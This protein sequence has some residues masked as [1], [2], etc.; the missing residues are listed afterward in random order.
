METPTGPTRNRS[1]AVVLSL[2]AT[3]LG[4][5]YCGRLGRGLVMFL[6]SLLFAPVIVVAA[7]MPPAT[8][9]LAGLILALLTVLGIHVFSVVDA[10]K[11]SRQ[12]CVLVQSNS[13]THPLV[14]PLY[15]L[16]GLTYQAG[17]LYFIRSNIFEAFVV[18]SASEVPTLLPGDRF[19]VNKTT[20]QRRPV[21]RGDVVVFRVPSEPC[22]KWVKRVIALPGDTV[23]VKDN[24]V[25]VN[26]NRLER[27]RL[28]L[29][30][31][32]FDATL[33]RGEV[34]QETNAG[35][36]YRI[37]LASESKPLPDYPKATVP[38]GCCFLLGDNRNNSR[39]SRMLGFVPLDNLLGDV[40]YRFLPIRNWS[41]FGAL[42]E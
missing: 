7:L 28:P 8:F 26:G 27:E 11:L 39:D 18:P 2:A 29:A 5:V 10:F 41:R 31:L 16:V 22:L 25:F 17:G 35:H 36:R 12:T 32:G 37:L 24:E 34:F 21:R 42:A 4:Q 20:Y 9:V 3:G 13:R 6:C 30:S 38:N 33:F 14:Y 15:I 1:A 23:E 40:Q 19:L